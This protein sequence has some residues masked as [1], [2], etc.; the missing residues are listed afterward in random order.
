[1]GN[2]HARSLFA[3]EVISSNTRC[4]ESIFFASLGEI[5]K[6]AAS[7]PSECIGRTGVTLARMQQRIWSRAVGF[8][9]GGQ[10]VAGQECP[11]TGVLRHRRAPKRE[12]DHRYPGASL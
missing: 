11:G 2:F 8:H 1:M 7:D 3:S 6:K 4:C 10:I 12:T 5:P 9:R